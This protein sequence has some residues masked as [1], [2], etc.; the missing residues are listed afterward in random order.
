VPRRA[1]RPRSCSLAALDQEAAENDARRHLVVSVPQPGIVAALP[2]A[3]GQAVQAGQTLA[4]LM[5][6]GAAGRTSDL[7]AALYAPS[8]AAGFVQAGQRVWLRYAAFPYQKFGLNGGVVTAISRTPILPHDLPAG[9]QQALLVAAQSNEPLYRIDVGL[10]AQSVSA[11][12]QRFALRPGM[13]VEADVVQD[14]RAVWEWLLEPVIA[15]RQRARVFGGRG[16][17]AADG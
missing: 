1:P 16:E 6:R 10:D 12:G 8:R 7:H 14:R 11:Y 2:V 9:H 3:V 13:T 5:P 15:A 4:T 17:S